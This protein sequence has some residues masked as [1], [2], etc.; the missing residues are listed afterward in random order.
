[1]EYISIRIQTPGDVGAAIRAQ[2]RKL[3]WGQAELAEKIGASRL[4]VNQ[5]E[6][7]KPGAEVGRVLRALHVLGLTLTIAIP[8]EPNLDSETPA[9]VPVI[10]IDAIVE[11]ARKGSAT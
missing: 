4:W 1:M 11:S 10:D 6:G 2:R 3:G 9:R 7:G 5:I 8:G